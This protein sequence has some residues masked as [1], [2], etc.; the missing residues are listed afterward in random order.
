MSATVYIVTIDD[1]HSGPYPYLYAQKENALGRAR[2]A[3]AEAEAHYQT[4]ADREII[5]SEIYR[6]YIE[7]C[8]TVT[9]EEAKLLDVEDAS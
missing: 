9:V 7:D 3:T 1:R 4:V 6:S 5:G 2:E 8:C